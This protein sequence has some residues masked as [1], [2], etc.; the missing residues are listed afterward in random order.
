MS[1][2][3]S[4]LAKGQGR[5]FL[6]AVLGIVALFSG[7]IPSA[8]ASSEPLNGPVL[9]RYCEKMGYDEAVIDPQY[10]D[11]NKYPNGPDG[12]SWRCA[13]L[14]YHNASS[15]TVGCS[16]GVSGEVT[17]QGPGVGTSVSCSAE[18]GDS[19]GS[20][21]VPR[22]A[23]INIDLACAFEYGWQDEENPNLWHTLYV[24]DSTDWSDPDAL[25]C[26]YI[27]PTF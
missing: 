7:S 17:L 2:A 1:N 8:L 27:G 12:R 10:Y 14:T 21:T 11:K 25:V 13:A 4:R 20:E 16:A 9:D 23:S 24:G 19:R 6:V 5:L 18:I 3:F 22:L 26:T 15:S